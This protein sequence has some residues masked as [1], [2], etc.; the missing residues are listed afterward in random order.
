MN[1]IFLYVINS[2][3]VFI[4]ISPTSHV[5]LHIFHQKKKKVQKG[6]IKKEQHPFHHFTFDLQDLLKKIIKKGVFF[7]III[8]G[9]LNFME[10]K[11]LDCSIFAVF[12]VV[13]VLCTGL[14][15]GGDIVHQD[16][17]AP[18]RPGCNNNFVLVIFWFLI[19]TVFFC[20]SVQRLSLF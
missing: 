4:H 5:F 11:K 8:L 17:I 12:V 19:S 13:V 15:S 9:L 20:V 7:L 3:L 10:L 18:S 2:L 1:I 16:D 14:V 6:I